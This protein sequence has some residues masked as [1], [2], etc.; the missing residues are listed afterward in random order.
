MLVLV[1]FGIS[2]VILTAIYDST[3]ALDTVPASA[4]PYVGNDRLFQD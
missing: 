1:V 3:S 4:I 2:I